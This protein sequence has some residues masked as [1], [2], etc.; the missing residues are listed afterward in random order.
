MGADRLYSDLLSRCQVCSPTSGSDTALADSHPGVSGSRFGQ[1]LAWIGCQIEL[2]RAAARRSLARLRHTTRWR[3]VRRGRHASPSPPS[4]RQPPRGHPARLP[5]P[6]HPLQ[7]EHRLDTPTTS[8]RQRKPTSRLTS[9]GPGVTSPASTCW[10]A[11]S[12]CTT[13]SACARRSP[14]L[15]NYSG[16][17]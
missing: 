15:G 14:S 5:Q 10:Y 13:A 2:G 16:P 7:R 8:T 9:T 4:A 1:L 3:S 17:G 6:P 11:T 12:P